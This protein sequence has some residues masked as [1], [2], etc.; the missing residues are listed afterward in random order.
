M[1]KYTLVRLGFAGAL[2]ALGIG[3]THVASACPHCPGGEVQTNCSGSTGWGSAVQICGDEGAVEGFGP[4]T[5]QAASIT[6][7]LFKS[8]GPEVNLCT[9]AQGT[10]GSQPTIGCVAEETTQG[11][12]NVNQTPDC[13]GDNGVNYLLITCNTQ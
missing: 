10:F 7:S 12:S 2:V 11:Q 6:A 1:N 3:S 5:T 4:T 13:N 8:S 9:D